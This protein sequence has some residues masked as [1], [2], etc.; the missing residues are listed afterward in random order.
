M[1]MDSY[2]S[3]TDSIH[4]INVPLPPSL[5]SHFVRACSGHLNDLSARRE[6]R[7]AQDEFMDEGDREIYMQ[8][9][10]EEETALDYMA[11]G[12]DMILRFDEDEEV[13]GAVEGLW[14]K[15]AQVKSMVL[16]GV[17]GF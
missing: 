15:I 13:R 3:F 14:Q 8:E 2:K 11:K 17:E 9:Q 1:L 16:G 10:E 5:M 6:D 7:L 4:V 12:F